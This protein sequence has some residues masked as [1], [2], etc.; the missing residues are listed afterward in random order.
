MHPITVKALYVENKTTRIPCTVLFQIGE[1][2]KQD[3][4]REGKKKYFELEN[5]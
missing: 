1:E 5:V 3:Y 2:K 4:Y